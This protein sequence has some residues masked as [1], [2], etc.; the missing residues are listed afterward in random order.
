MAENKKKKS[1]STTKSSSSSG[2]VWGI[3]KVAM[4]TIIAV[5][6]L[7]LVSTILSFIPLDLTLS[8]KVIGILNGLATA[9]MITIVSILAWRHVSK[10]NATWQVMFFICL[11]VV[12]LGVVIPLVI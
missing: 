1:S 6:V 8:Y 9:V 3:N 4:Y 5:A 2:A 11:L 10:K 7:Y 12:F